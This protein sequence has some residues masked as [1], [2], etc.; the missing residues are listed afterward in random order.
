WRRSG[1]QSQPASQPASEHVPGGS[2]MDDGR[3][4]LPGKWIKPDGCSKLT[5]V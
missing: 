4:S 1:S 2:S 3:S 5:Q